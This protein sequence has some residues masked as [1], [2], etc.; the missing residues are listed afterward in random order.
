MRALIIALALEMLPAIVCGTTDGGNPMRLTL[1]SSA[2]SEGQKIP[3]RFTCAGDDL[4]PALAWQGIPTGTK[5]LALIADDPD[6]PVG[7]WVHWVLFN[8]PAEKTSLP[9]GLPPDGQ[10]PDGSRQGTN[11]FKRLGY[12][13]PCPP[14]GKPHR[15]FFKL[16]A[17]D[18]RLDLPPGASKAQVLD[19]IR[20]HILA[21]A[22]LMG[23]YRR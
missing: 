4:S 23:R 20:G 14:P 9:E 7:T 22:A 8:I 19:A 1:T 5:G 2:F 18:Q 13:G 3:D 12:G 17:T 15:Y 16:Y 11:D 6:A 21:E 10:L